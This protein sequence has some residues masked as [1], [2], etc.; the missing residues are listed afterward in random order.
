MRC[1]RMSCVGTWMGAMVLGLAATAHAGPLEKAGHAAA[2]GKWDEAANLYAAALAKR[3]ACRAAAVGLVDAAARAKRPAL[4]RAA[5]KP[6]EKLH[7][8]APEDWDVCVALG[9]CCLELA[10]LEKRKDDP[11]HAQ[12]MVCFRAAVEANPTSDRAAAGLARTLCAYEDYEKAA[13]VVD[14]FLARDPERAC[15]SLYWKGKS[16][17]ELAMARYREVGSWTSEIKAIFRR[18]QEALDGAVRGDER[19]FDAWL[20]L[21]Y[22]ATY[23]GDIDTGERAYLKAFVLEPES[24]KPLKGLKTLMTH[25]PARYERLM[26]RLA[27]DHPDHPAMLRP[28]IEAA[29]AAEDWKGAHR[30]LSRYLKVNEASADGWFMMGRACLGLKKKKDA[31]DAFERC[32]RADPD[33]VRAADHLEKEILRSALVRNAGKSVKSARKLID[34]YEELLTLAPRNIYIRNNLAFTLREAHARHKSSKKWLPI[35]K[36]CTQYYVEASD[37]VGDWDESKADWSW[38]RRYASAQILNDTGLMF[39]YYKKTRDLKKAEAY[40]RS[41]MAYT[42]HGY[43]DAYNNLAAILQEQKRWRELY[44]YAKASAEGIRHENGEP[45]EVTREAARRMMESLR[46]KGRAK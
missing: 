37:L 16:L 4:M 41:A 1:V 19:C 25:D 31:L 6:L 23:T 45:D 18:S 32:L 42:D 3:P 13:E 5:R 14:A 10:S 8:K 36:A 46:A 28:K 2:A 9:T 22:A 39:Q 30:L 43:V 7:A 27:D 11:L 29:I 40:Y 24:P 20:A 17:Y 35:L 26:T 34:G 33:H 15:R 12:A 44:D 21:G 38:Q